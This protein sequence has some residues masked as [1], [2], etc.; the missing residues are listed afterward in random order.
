MDCH[1]NSLRSFFCNDSIVEF[2][3]LLWI[4]TLALLSLA[5]TAQAKFM[6]F[7]GLLKKFYFVR[8]ATI[9]RFRVDSSNDEFFF[10]IFFAKNQ[11]R[12]IEF[13]RYFT[14]LEKSKKSTTKNK[15]NSDFMFLCLAG[16]FLA[17]AVALS[18]YPHI[19]A[20]HTPHPNPLYVFAEQV[21]FF[22][23]SPKAVLAVCL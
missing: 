23:S 13:W 3:L 5:M 19:Y 16:C 14:L 9:L 12:K 11:Y 20:N 7:C 22:R 4:A 2:I 15:T 17:L 10:D 1:E 18:R 6:S 21:R 8:F